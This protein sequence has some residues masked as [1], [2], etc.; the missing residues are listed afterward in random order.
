M[1]NPA[2]SQLQ[3]NEPGRAGPAIRTSDSGS[4]AVRNRWLVGMAGMLVMTIL[5]TIYS[6]SL[7]TQP[8]IASFGWSNTTTTWTFALAIF[9]LGLGALAGGRWQ[10]RVGPRKVV[11]TGVVMWG[12]GNMLAGLGTPYLGAWWMYATTGLSAALAS[13]WDTLRRSPS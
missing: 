3:P 5:G 4:S 8:L 12:M 7:F 13:A 9:F 2:P 11:L 1:L 10:D 6:W